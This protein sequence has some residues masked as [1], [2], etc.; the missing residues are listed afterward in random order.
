M[1]HPLLPLVTPH[2]LPTY[3]PYPLKLTPQLTPSS[4]HHSHALTSLR[5]SYVSFPLTYAFIPF[6]PYVGPLNSLTPRN[7]SLPKLTAL[8]PYLSRLTSI[9]FPLLHAL[10]LPLNHSIHSLHSL[11]NS[12]HALPMFPPPHSYLREVDPL[13]FLVGVLR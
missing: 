13:E 6:S 5:N 8:P 4:S 2:S 3:F 7:H 1:R 11:H 10:D 12:S 9:R